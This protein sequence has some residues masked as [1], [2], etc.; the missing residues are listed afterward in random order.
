MDFRFWC[1]SLYV[2]G[3]KPRMDNSGVWRRQPVK[4]R[5][6]WSI[7]SCQ[8]QVHETW[9]LNCQGLIHISKIVM[10]YLKILRCDKWFSFAEFSYIIFH[11]VKLMWWTFAKYFSAAICDPEN[12]MVT[13][14]LLCTAPIKVGS[15][16]RIIVQ[17]FRNS[18]FSGDWLLPRFFYS[19]NLQITP[20][21]ITKEQ[22]KDH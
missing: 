9:L 21:P 1:V 8:F 10:L 3:S 16:Y 15:V 4:W 14:P 2:L 5:L 20:I 19:I 13:P 12:N 18:F 11:Y 7:F 6:G 17:A 22:E